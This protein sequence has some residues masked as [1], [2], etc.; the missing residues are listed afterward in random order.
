MPAFL[1]D[2]GKPLPWAGLA[3]DPQKGASWQG[4]AQLSAGHPSAAVL[5]RHWHCRWRACQTTPS[6]PLSPHRLDPVIGLWPGEATGSGPRFLDV[7][8]QCGVH[9]PPAGLLALCCC[10][11]DCPSHSACSVQVAVSHR[12][13]LRKAAPD[14]ADI[15]LGL[16]AQQYSALAAQGTEQGDAFSLLP[17]KWGESSPY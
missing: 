14:T 3:S 6:R 7:A 12:L 13:E 10:S 16:V 17:P 11:E 2:Q 1:R 4:F 5:G 15:V 9:R 8:G